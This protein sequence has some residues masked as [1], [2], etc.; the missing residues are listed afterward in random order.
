MGKAEVGELCY[1]MGKVCPIVKPR[2]RKTK[3]WEG[4]KQLQMTLST[5]LDPA[6]PEVSLDFSVIEDN[7]FPF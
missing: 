3:L 1:L 7:I 4:E 2:S 5:C 6:V